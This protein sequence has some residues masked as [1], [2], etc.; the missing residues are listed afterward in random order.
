MTTYGFD[1]EK[2]RE[3][4]PMVVVSITN[5]C[6]QKCAHCH[7]PAFSQRPDYHALEMPWEIWTRIV[8]E[9]AQH[10]WSI[11]NLGTDGEPLIHR[12]FAE[13]MRYAKGKGVSPINL[14]TNGVLL[15]PERAEVLLGENL[16]D[17]INISLDAFTAETYERI[18]G[19][20]HFPKVR[21]N[22]LDLIALRD[23]LGSAAKIQVNFIDQPEAHGE[24]EDFKAYW[25]PLVDNVMIRTY[26][27]ATHV[28]GKPGPD[29]TGKQVPFPPEE[30]WPCQQFWRRMNVSEDGTVRYCVDDWYN[31]SRLGHVAESSL[32]EIWQGADYQHY[33]TLH[34]ERR[35]HENPFCA[36][37]TEWQ[38][39]RWDF[40]Y[41]VAMEKMLGKKLL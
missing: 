31:G 39:M 5:L 35:F 32:K 22:V 18:R 37:C 41:F 1:S 6:N 13:M 8:D 30:R 29:M 25:Q 21:Q 10:P 27:D 17:V 26:Y 14:T 11:L 23:R 16:I 9:M 7:W 36:D 19:T 15:T 40:D 4:P 24:V 28:I 3:F 2:T 20:R 38:G 12:R 33:R 34:Q